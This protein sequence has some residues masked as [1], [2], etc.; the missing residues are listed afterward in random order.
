MS[1]KALVNKQLK[2]THIMIANIFLNTIINN[3][4][5]FQLSELTQ[6]RVIVLTDAEETKPKTRVYN[7]NENKKH[8]C[9]FI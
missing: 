1:L 2:D 5:N 8:G 4:A 9:Y 7:T 6:K 3:T